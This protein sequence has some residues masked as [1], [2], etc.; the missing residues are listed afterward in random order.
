[1]PRNRGDDLH[2]EN[3]WMLVV[4]VFFAG[5]A[6]SIGGFYGAK[7]WENYQIRQDFNELAHRFG[8]EISGF[9]EEYLQEFQAVAGSFPP[10]VTNQEEFDQF[11]SSL[12]KIRGN[13]HAV[14]WVPKIQGLTEGNFHVR[15]IHP[16]PEN[17]ELVGLD[18]E[19]DPLQLEAMTKACD[20]G[21]QYAAYPMQGML[22]NSDH[23]DSLFVYFPVYYP[24]PDSVRAPRRCDNLA[25]YILHIYDLKKMAVYFVKKILPEEIQ[26]KIY[27]SSRLPFD[28]S[29]IGYTQ[30]LNFAGAN[31]SLFFSPTLQYEKERTS[32]LHW[33]VFGI[34]L[35]IT[36]TFVI[37]LADYIHETIQMKK[38][39]QQV[40]FPKPS[41]SDPPAI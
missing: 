28:L 26:L 4:F 9:L 13:A 31:V 5:I 36:V 20:E 3:Q 18:L 15:F 12:L 37:C 25:G 27:D 24:R 8:V 10:V 21:E 34:C 32:S 29:E 40:R 14:A 30:E 35:L 41:Q 38:M 22:K 16:F 17:K 6:L 33:W 19:S 1:M 7:A 39:L 2:T 11:V 23:S